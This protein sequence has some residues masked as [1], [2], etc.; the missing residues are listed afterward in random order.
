MMG[1]FCLITLFVLG[2]TIRAI[3][4]TCLPCDSSKC[5]LPVNCPVGTVKDVCDC[6]LECAKGLNEVCGGPWEMFGKCAPGLTCLKPTASP[7]WFNEGGR[8]QKI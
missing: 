5:P 7:D 1:K 6:C 4:L 8:C 3:A 2:V